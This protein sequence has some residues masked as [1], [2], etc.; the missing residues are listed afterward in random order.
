MS[1][2]VMMAWKQSS[3]LAWGHDTKKAP[4]GANFLC[5]DPLAWLSELSKERECIK[6]SI[7]MLELIL[8]AETF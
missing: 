5:H 8:V 2:S 3:L 1:L 4:E 7:Q 6:S